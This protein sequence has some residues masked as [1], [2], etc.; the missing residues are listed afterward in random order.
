MQTIARRIREFRHQQKMTLKDL[1]AKVGCSDSYVSQLEHGRSSPSVATLKKIASAFGIHVVHFFDDGPEDRI[2]M[3]KHERPR[4]VFEEGKAEINSLIFNAK[5]KR[6]EALYTVLEP[7][8]GSMGAIH[9][10]GEE[11]GIVLSGRL[12]LTV[13]GKAYRLTA[14]DSFSFDSSLPHEYRNPGRRKTVIIW[15]ITPPT[16]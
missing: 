10:I 1:A 4:L 12:D 9:H 7:R 6:I 2:V 13:G 14:G 3:R 15:I 5:N 8:G 11:F 16:F